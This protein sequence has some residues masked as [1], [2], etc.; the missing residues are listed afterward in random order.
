ML[1]RIAVRWRRGGRGGGRPGF[2]V[3]QTE[4]HFG[5]QA[6]DKEHSGPRPRERSKSTSE[7]PRPPSES[8]P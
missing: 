2:D 4:N 1:D 6:G 5:T 3:I 8:P 7:L